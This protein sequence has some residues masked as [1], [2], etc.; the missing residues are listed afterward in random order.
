M[1]LQKV[2]K[3]PRSNSSTQFKLA[4]TDSQ[5]TRNILESERKNILAKGYIVQI[6]GLDKIYL[7]PESKQF[8]FQDTGNPPTT[9]SASSLCSPIL[10]RALHFFIQQRNI[11]HSPQHLEYMIP[12]YEDS[13]TPTFRQPVHYLSICAKIFFA[14]KQTASFSTLE[15]L[16]QR[17]LR[18][19]Y[20]GN[21]NGPNSG[22]K[23]P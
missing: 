16:R 19:A 12:Q 4:S 15:I 23:V 10:H 3:K 22:G 8:R 13:L 14:R 17:L 6:H 2:K 18:A 21:E 7:G 20:A 1:A 5:S 9:T 11:T